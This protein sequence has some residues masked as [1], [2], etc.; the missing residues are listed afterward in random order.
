VVAVVCSVF[1]SRPY[2]TAW[3]DMTGVSFWGMGLDRPGRSGGGRRRAAAAGGGKFGMGNIGIKKK[4][5][6]GIKQRR[7]G[8][9]FFFFFPF[10]FLGFSLIP[11][12]V[13]VGGKR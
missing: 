5:G 10:L 6:F 8:A 9:G 12:C 11:H 1:F 13:S 3:H 2:G 4:G 7:G